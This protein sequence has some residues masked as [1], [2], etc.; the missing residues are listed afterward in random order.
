MSS[1]ASGELF[2]VSGRL[3]CLSCRFLFITPG[4]VN[5]M[6]RYRRCCCYRGR[7]IPQRC[8]PGYY[9]GNGCNTLPI[10]FVESIALAPS[11]FIAG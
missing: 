7:Q 4:Q 3:D 6:L 8:K 5:P 2:V 10:K 11:P 1:S 9:N